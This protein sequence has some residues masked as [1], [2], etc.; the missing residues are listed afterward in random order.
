MKTR[1]YVSDQEVDSGYNILRSDRNR[2][3]GV[4]CS[5]S[6]NLCFN[7]R[8]IFSNRNENAFCQSTNS[9]S[10]AY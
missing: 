4:A 7:R 1:C 6:A 9:N 8:N 2:N 3:G 10:E 5:I